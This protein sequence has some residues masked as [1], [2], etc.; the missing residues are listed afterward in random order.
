M[1]QTLLS[2]WPLFFGLAMIMIGNGLQG[3]L[4]GVRASIEGFSTLT[5]GVIMSLYYF[6]FLAGSYYV[7]KL[8]VS[9]GH[10][11]VFA[12]LASLASTT[13]LFHGLFGDPVTWGV[14]RIFTGFAYAGLF[15]VIESW[16]NQAATN[17]TR[18]QMMAL[19][20]IVTYA[21]MTLG[22]FLLNI[23]SPKDIELF[24]MTSVLVSIALLPISLSSRPA[25][26]FSEPET[27][28]IKSIYKRSPLGVYGVFTSGLA[29]SALFAIGAVYAAEIG[30][31]LPQISTFM[32][33]FIAGGVLFQ[34]PIGWLSDRYDRRMV[35]IAVCALTGLF[36]IA[37]LLAAG[38]SFAGLSLFMLLAGGTA[39]SIYGLSIAHTND[40]LPQNQ[41]VAAS[42]TMILLNGAASCIG[43]LLATGLMS[44]FGSDAFF[45]YLTAI[46]LMMAGFGLY[47]TMVHPSV[48]LDD[49]G[50]Y[51]PL[52]ARPS[53]F[54]MQIAEDSTATMKE[55]DEKA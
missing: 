25:P 4:L 17:K 42:A 3:T 49:Q 50:D 33:A 8:I 37:A 43:P 15:I 11:R 12:A 30:M 18:G 26:V 45:I 47:R 41:I 54:V 10:I 44:W 5:T 34:A 53:P 46:Y 19:Y 36:C 7:P 35:L 21:G 1:R 16:L 28:S 9:V 27:T 38:Q 24:V 40:H 55:M 13:V 31:T 48:P 29:A 52:A 39:L 6:G 20:L 51:V 14:V 32:A 2:A 23:A 22:Q